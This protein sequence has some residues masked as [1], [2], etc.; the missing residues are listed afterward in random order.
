MVLSSVANFY[1][2]IC[3]NDVIAKRYRVLND[4]GEM[5]A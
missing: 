3:D 1:F 5:A 4:D 2:V